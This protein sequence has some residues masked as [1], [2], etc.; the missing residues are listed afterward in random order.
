MFSIDRYGIAGVLLCTLL[1]L[2]GVTPGLGQQT[3]DPDFDPHVDKPAFREKHP[4]VL[5]DE[6]HHNF[7]TASGRYKAFVDLITHDGYRGT[8]GD[9]GESLC[10]L[11]SPR[12]LG[13]KGAPAAG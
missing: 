12:Q 1:F 10:K 5:F 4:T 7:H 3:S 2:L 6:A 8:Q 13:K 9:S 11:P